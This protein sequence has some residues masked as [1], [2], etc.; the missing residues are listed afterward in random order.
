MDYFFPLLKRL[1]GVPSFFKTTLGSSFFASVL[2]L[3][4]FLGA[5]CACVLNVNTK[6]AI[7]AKI[8]FSF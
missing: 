2:A 6:R 1:C 7:T 8:N 3:Y 5:Y 4:T